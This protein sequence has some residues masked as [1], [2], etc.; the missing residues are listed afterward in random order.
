MYIPRNIRTQ[1][2][3]GFA[4]VRFMKKEDAEDAQRGM[5]GKVIDGREIRIAEGCVFNPYLS[6]N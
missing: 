5:D 2:G 6:V 3:R 1:E 4:F